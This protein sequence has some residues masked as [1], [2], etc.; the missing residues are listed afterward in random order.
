MFKS[1]SLAIA[2]FVA[3]LFLASC[4][5]PQAG[6]SGDNKAPK[7]IDSRPVGNPRLN[8]SFAAT[9]G[10]VASMFN[11]ISIVSELAKSSHNRG[12]FESQVYAKIKSGEIKADKLS[13]NYDDGTTKVFR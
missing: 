13:V 3:V 9:S 12:E 1:I 5:A 10:N 4:V 7:V 8:G 6:S 11:N 2:T